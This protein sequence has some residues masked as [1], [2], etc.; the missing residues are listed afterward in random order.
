[1]V[2]NINKIN[3]NTLNE[4]WEHINDWVDIVKEAKPSGRFTK[5]NRGDHFWLKNISFNI[6][7]PFHLKHKKIFTE[8]EIF[9]YENLVKLKKIISN[10]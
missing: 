1:M 7:Y 10:G 2:E 8:N 4:N 3:F 6:K 5:I 9:S